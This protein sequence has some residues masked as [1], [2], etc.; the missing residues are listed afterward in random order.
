[1]LKIELPRLNPKE[2]STLHQ[3]RD[4]M[5]KARALRSSIADSARKIRPE[6]LVAL[7]CHLFPGKSNSEAVEAL[8]NDAMALLNSL[9]LHGEHFCA[10]STARAREQAPVRSAAARRHFAILNRLSGIEGEIRNH[11]AK[12]SAQR[13]RMQEAGLNGVD[14][15]RLAPL[16][17][18]TTLLEEREALQAEDE[19]LTRFLSSGDERDLPAD[20]VA[21][22]IPKIS[23]A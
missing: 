2:V 12:I 19:A 4:L 13:K 14:L 22:E 16:G 6:T 9:V 3:E 20:F 11:E 10:A 23:A 8:H 21:T 18:P 17:Q 1:M 5:V 7:A 15:D